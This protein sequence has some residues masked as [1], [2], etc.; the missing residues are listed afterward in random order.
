MD[1]PETRYVTT[2]DGV[3]IAYQRFGRDTPGGR[4]IVWIPHMLFGIDL[5]WDAAPIAR[6]LEGLGTLG[7]VVIRDIRGTGL[8]DR[9]VEPGDAGTDVADLMTILDREGIERAAIIGNLRGGAVAA[10]AAATH[11]DRV[12]ELV[13]WHPIVRSARAPDFPWGA[14]DEELAEEVARMESAW[15]TAAQAEEMASGEG[16]MG[17]IDLSFQQWVARMTRSAITPGRARRLL[18]RFQETDVRDV[19]PSISSPTLVLAR[20]AGQPEARAWIASRIPGARQVTLPGKDFMPWFGDLRVVLE[21][22]GRFL[23]VERDGG[24][25]GRFLATV[26]FTDVVDSTSRAAELGDALWRDLLERHHGIVRDRLARFGGREQDTAGDG[27]F[28]AFDAPA[29]AVRCA[30]SIVEAMSVIGLE[31]RIGIHTGEAQLVDRKVGGLAVTIGAR[32][33]GHAPPSGIVVTSTVKELVVG[34]GLTFEDA[35]EHELKG[36]PDRWRLYRVVG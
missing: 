6:W 17:S 20:E 32:V 27:F 22:I 10:L 7:Q 8:S 3:E 35:G 28:A 30:S 11:P 31:V 21:A 19:L 5:W 18:Q 24:A 29:D 15:G 36:V 4:D 16:P 14:S 2:P 23:G 1:R 13:L 25:T 33:A 34:S 12:S 26:L 9:A